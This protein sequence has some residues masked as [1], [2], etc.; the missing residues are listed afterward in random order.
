MVLPPPQRPNLGYKPGQ[1]DPFLPSSSILS[2]SPLNTLVMPSR[3]DLLASLLAAPATLTLGRAAFAQ[4]TPLQAAAAAVSD[5][6]AISR[7]AL[8]AFAR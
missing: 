4:T 7:D 2:Q 6:Q 8:L 3:R 1:S 5:G